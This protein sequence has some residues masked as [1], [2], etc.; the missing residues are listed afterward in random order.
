MAVARDI[1]VN[2]VR[3]PLIA[4]NGL[5]NV[6]RDYT[7]YYDETNNI[8]RLHV[9]ADGFNVKEPTCFVLGGVAHIGQPRPLDLAS[10]KAA[11]RLQLT[12]KELKLSHLGKGDVL[13]LLKSWRVEAY[14]DWLSAEGLLVHYS[15]VDPLYWSIVDIVDSIISHDR[16]RHMQRFHLGLK[17]DLLTVLGADI[18]DVAGLLHQYSYPNVGEARRRGFVEELLAR[19]EH[20]ADLL[21]E[22][23]AQVLK[24]VLQAGGR[25]EP[26]IY[27]DD[28]PPN[29]L[30]DSFVEFFI[31]RICLF[32]NGVHRLDVEPVIQARLQDCTFRDGDQAL[33]TYAFVDSRGEPGV[34]ISDALIGLLGKLFSYVTRTDPAELVAVRRALTP[35]QA[36]AL[37]K[38]ND[39][40]DRSAAETPALLHQIAS[41]RAM[42]AGQFFLEGQ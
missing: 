24:G 36:R 1:D 9:T 31:H 39:L 37:G 21:P 40:L 33:D 19:L 27:L 6:D 5:T 10:L 25:A 32:K 17:A 20:R 41:T 38:L 22:F 3:D 30:L 34:Q 35:V 28:E 42:R 8:R 2:E 4:L 14:L 12:A 7:F 11:V 15:A 16:M 18:N 29:T 23:N 26:L 13:D